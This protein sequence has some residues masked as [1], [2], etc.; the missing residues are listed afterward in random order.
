MSNKKKAAILILKKGKGPCPHMDEEK[1]E[2]VDEENDETPKMPEELMK[3]L[4]TKMDKVL[5]RLAEIGEEELADH[6][7]HD[8]SSRQGKAVVV[9][10]ADR[11]VQDIG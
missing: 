11:Q 4:L 10:T 9:P 8:R 7:S 3:A 2:E 6:V 1:V 5:E